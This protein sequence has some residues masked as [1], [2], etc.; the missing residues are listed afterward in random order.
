MF[1]KFGLDTENLPL[2]ESDPKE[3]SLSNLTPWPK[4]LFSL[5]PNPIEFPVVPIPAT[6]N[7]SPVGFSV[8][9]TLM[10]LVL[11]LS[12]SITSFLTLLK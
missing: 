12:N 1:L 8:T 5:I 3:I 4:K 7:N 9:E 2:I 10:I 11:V 6:A